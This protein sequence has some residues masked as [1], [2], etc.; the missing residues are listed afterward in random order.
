[1]NCQ[2]IS[3]IRGQVLDFGLDYPVLYMTVLHLREAIGMRNWRGGLLKNG[4]VL[5]GNNAYL[6]MHCMATVFPNVS[7][8]GKDGYNFSIVSFAFVL[9]VPLDSLF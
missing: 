8:G 7:L 6:N 5:F 2:A 9:S 1:L 3:D 4:L